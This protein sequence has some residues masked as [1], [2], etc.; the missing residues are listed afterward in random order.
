MKESLNPVIDAILKRRSIRRYNGKPVDK[1]IIRNL[2]V[3]GMYAPSARNRQPWH[4]IV[5]DN[6]DQLEQM[7]N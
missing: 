7:V 5:I 3:A 2:L 4:F 1:S 6:R